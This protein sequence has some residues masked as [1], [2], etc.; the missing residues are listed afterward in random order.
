MKVINHTIDE[1]E[2][3]ISIGQNEKDNWLII[4][5]ADNDD[6]WFHV[7]NKP[8]CHVILHQK[9]KKNQKL[10]Y[11]KQIV[12]MCANCCANS[13]KGNCK[14]VDVIFTK[15]NNIKK[16]RAIGSVNI[17][18]ESRVCKIKTSTVLQFDLDLS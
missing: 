13:L 8:S 15:I 7:D 3:V 12:T 18:N 14:K 6:L 11:S 10:N 1:Y 9:P 2:Y 5:N 17:I 16:G 4:D